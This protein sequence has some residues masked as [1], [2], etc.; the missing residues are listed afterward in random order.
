MGTVDE[1][2]KAPNVLAAKVSNYERK[3]IVFPIIDSTDR[4]LSEN[5]MYVCYDADSLTQVY[6]EKSKYAR[7]ID[8]FHSTLVD[9]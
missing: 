1:S 2:Y 7:L 9:N 4:P 6:I 5:S 8:T 3:C